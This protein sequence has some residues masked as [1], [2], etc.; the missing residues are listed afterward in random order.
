MRH[1]NERK[2]KGG[3]AM[4]KGVNKRI[5]EIPFPEN[6]YFEKAVMFIRHDAPDSSPAGITAQARCFAESLKSGL[7]APQ[8]RMQRLGAA[9]YTF[10]RVAAR[11]SVI[12]CAGYAVYCL[13]RSG[14]IF[15]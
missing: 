2:T 14:G 10:L 12:I 8:R 5:V 15:L 9:L 4:I 6:P 1:N 7:S 11:I 3:K 13:Y